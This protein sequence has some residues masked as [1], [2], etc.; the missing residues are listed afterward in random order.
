MDEIISENKIWIASFDIGKKN[1]AFYIE[2]IDINAL[3]LVETIPKESRYNKNGTPTPVF[4]RLLKKIWTNGKTILFRNNDITDG[5]KSG[6]Y[7]DTEL[8]YNMMD[9]LDEYRTYWDRCSI[10]VMEQQMS[11][12][13][14]HN[15]MALKLGQ[16]CFSYFIFKYGRFKTVIE[17]PSYYKTQILGAEKDEKILK[18]GKVS[19]KAVDKLSRKKWSVVKASEILNDRDDTVTLQEL[20]SKKKK[21]DLADVLCQLQAFKFLHFVDKII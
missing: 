5:C 13:K 11:F 19:Y 14:K 9:L 8:Y 3:S 21:D 12:G 7:I 15:T 16:N 4:G 10:F 6:S 2:E 1:F 17:F 18:S 20:T